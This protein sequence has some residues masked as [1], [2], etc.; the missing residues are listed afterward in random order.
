M[1]GPGQLRCPTEGKVG[2]GCESESRPCHSL[3]AGLARVGT[4]RGGEPL[5]PIPVS[6]Q[7]A[8][9]FLLTQGRKGKSLGEAG[10]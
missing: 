8:P 5:S 9:S 7:R 6:P 2:C 10:G 4:A 3:P 1:A